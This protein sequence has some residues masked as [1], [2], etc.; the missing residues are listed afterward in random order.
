MVLQLE[1]CIDILKFTHPDFDFL[2][3]FDHSNGRDH[4]CPNG[5][6]IN[7]INLKFGGCQPIMQS[8]KL[9]ISKF[10]PFHNSTY[11]L[12]PGM[13]QEMQ[14]TPTHEGPCYMPMDERIS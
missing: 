7:K 10:D 12:Q 1:D 14:F 3:M 5:L 6:N 8:S 11:A 2:F 4:L 9:T 13:V